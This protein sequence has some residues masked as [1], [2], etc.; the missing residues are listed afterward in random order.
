[1]YL[2]LSEEDRGWWLL[3]KGR[4]SQDAGD[5]VQPLICYLYQRAV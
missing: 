3:V 5:T 4:S 1:M 2:N